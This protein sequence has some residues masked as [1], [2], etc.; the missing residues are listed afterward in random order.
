MKIIA[1]KFKGKSLNFR[2]VQGIRPT[3]QKVKEAIFSILDKEVQDAVVL[4]LFCGM[5]NLGIEAISRG[6]KEVHFVDV[7]PKALKQIS[8]FLE[9]LEIEKQATLIKRDYLKALKHFEEEYFDLILI[10][11]PYRLNYEENSLR[12]ISKGNVLKPSGKVIVE[13]SSEINLP[14]QV[15]KFN[16]FKEK[17]YGDTALSLYSFAFSDKPEK[18]MEK[19]TAKEPEENPM[20]ENK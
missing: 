5:G 4:D 2:T 9:M 8:F 20:D 1:G 17:I 15:E 13:H 12:I 19:E 16:K 18:E 7:N 14:Q 10:D 3:S 11:P 6:A